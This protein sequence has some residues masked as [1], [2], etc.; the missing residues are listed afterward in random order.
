MRVLPGER[1][2]GKGLQGKRSDF[3]IAIPR[4]RVSQFL[5]LLEAG[6]L[7]GSCSVDGAYLPH[8]EQLPYWCKFQVLN[9]FD[10]QDRSLPGFRNG[11]H[12]FGEQLQSSFCHRVGRTAKAEGDVQ[13]VIA[14]H[15]PACPRPQFHFPFTHRERGHFLADAPPDRALHLLGRLSEENL[16]MAQIQREGLR[17][18]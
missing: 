7:R 15:P 16:S 14:Q 12:F 6:F 17:N 9:N 10:R 8:P 3:L 5:V 2:L 1:L 18:A 4:P 13:L 11:Q